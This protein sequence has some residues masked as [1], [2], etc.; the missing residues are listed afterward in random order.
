[1]EVY[2]LLKR[3][4]EHGPWTTAILGIYSTEEKAF[5]AARLDMEEYPFNPDTTEYCIETQCVQ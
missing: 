4:Y 5:E 1:M 3:E 2:I